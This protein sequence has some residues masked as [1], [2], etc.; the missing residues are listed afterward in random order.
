MKL[1]I[2]AANE[3]QKQFIA[4]LPLCLGAS[5]RSYH[6]TCRSLCQLL[7]V[8]QPFHVLR[9]DQRRHRRI[10]EIGRPHT[11]STNKS[12]AFSSI[13][14]INYAHYNRSKVGND[15]A[16]ASGGR[17]SNYVRAQ[18]VYG[19]FRPRKSWERRDHLHKWGRN[20]HSPSHRRVGIRTRAQN[21]GSCTR[22]TQNY[23][24][25]G[26]HYPETKRVR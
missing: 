3:K 7:A 9:L 26:H 8:L 13:H 1:I 19:R 4:R 25:D 18:L 16:M 11:R 5:C 17:D 23:P 2:V 14:G 6:H 24:P 22:R 15:M 12:Q 10:A 21:S 20:G